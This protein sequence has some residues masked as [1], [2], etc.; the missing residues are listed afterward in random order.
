MNKQTLIDDYK[1]TIER[2]QKECTEK[3]DLNIKLM[4]R[5]Q[6]LEFIINRLSKEVK[7]PYTLDDLITIEKLEQK[8]NAQFAEMEEKL[9]AE[10]MNNFELREKLKIARE[11]LQIYANS[12]MPDNLFTSETMN[13]I[14]IY[15]DNW[16]IKGKFNKPMYKVHYNTEIAQQALQKIKEANQ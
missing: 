8:L 16:C 4:E 15:T 6:E 10:E 3:T 12:V 14:A 7:A 1:Q 13:N 9:T 2:L 11:A 5:V